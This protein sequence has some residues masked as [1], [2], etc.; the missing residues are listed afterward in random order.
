MYTHYTR[1]YYNNCS[2]DELMVLSLKKGASISFHLSTAYIPLLNRQNSG[3]K[4]HSKLT[5]ELHA[6]SPIAKELW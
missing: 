1:S 2:L 5:A 6:R 4:T 3:L